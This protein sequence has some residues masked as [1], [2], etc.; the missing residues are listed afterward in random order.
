MVMKGEQRTLGKNV[1]AG[2][3]GF[4]CMSLTPGFYGTSK[5]IDLA[6]SEKVLRAAI[7]SGMTLLNTADFYTGFGPDE[8][9]SANIK[10]IGKV[11]KDYP[12]DSVVVAMKWGPWIEP[13]KGFAP[14]DMAP[15]ACKERVDKA[16]KILGTD[17]IDILTLRLGAGPDSKGTPL[18]ETARGMKE[19]LDSGKVKAIGVS[20]LSTADAKKIHSVVPVSAIE[21]E[22]NLFNREGEKELIPWARSVGAGV[23]AYAPMARGMLTGKLDLKNLPD[24]DFRKGGHNPQFNEDNVDGNLKLVYEVEKMAKSKGCT[25]GQLAVAWVLAQGK[26]VIP[27]PGTKRVKYLDENVKALDISLTDSEVQQLSNAIPRDKIQGNRTPESH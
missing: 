18:E 13:G 22:W 4:G 14:L 26:D 19:V 9:V 11:I 2:A 25:A 6:E 15:Q 3:L 20:E 10:L 24:N 1:H 16:L 17:Y 7:D 21:I 12:R 5:D 8:E 27:I 23:M